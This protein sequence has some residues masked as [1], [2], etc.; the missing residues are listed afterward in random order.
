MAIIAATYFYM[1]SASSVS[2]KFRYYFML[3][4]FTNVIA[5]LSVALTAAGERTLAAVL[6]ANTAAFVL[7]TMVNL[8]YF[9][10]NV[11]LSAYK[12]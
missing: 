10:S 11:L 4:G 2:E 1:S 12:R 6:W 3:L 9:V 8:I 7:F 5:T